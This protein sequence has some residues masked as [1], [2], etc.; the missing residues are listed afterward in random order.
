MASYTPS[1]PY[2]GYQG[3]FQLMHIR[4]WVTKVTGVICMPCDEVLS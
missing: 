1:H 2:V 4:M 3:E